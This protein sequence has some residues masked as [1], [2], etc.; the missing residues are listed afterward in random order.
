MIFFETMYGLMLMSLETLVASTAVQTFRVSNY[1]TEPTSNQQSSTTPNVER[2]YQSVLSINYHNGFNYFDRI[3]QGYYGG[4]VIGYDCNTHQYV[5]SVAPGIGEQSTRL[6]QYKPTNDYQMYSS[7]GLVEYV[8]FITQNFEGEIRGASDSD[9]KQR[10]QR[11]QIF[12]QL[13]TSKATIQVYGRTDYTVGMV[14]NL[15]VPA[16]KQI[17]EQTEQTSDVLVSGRY[18]VTSLKHVVTPSSHY[19]NLQLMKDSF[20][21]DISKPTVGTVAKQ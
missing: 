8:P 17:T 14:V 15:D 4:E 9:I 2:D 5:H 21:V 6:N 7:G 12:A 3:N 13:G 11:Q 1:A 20:I 19:C 18:L 10:I 16:P